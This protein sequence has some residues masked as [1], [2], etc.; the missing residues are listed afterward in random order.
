MNN[1]IKILILLCASYLSAFAQNRLSTPLEILTFM[2]ATGTHYQIEQLY[3]AVPSRPAP[4]LPHGAFIENIAGIEHTR[5]YKDF[6][7]CA[8]EQ[9]FAKARAMMNTEKPNYKK[10]RSYYQKILK[11]FP[12]D[13]Q[14]YTLVGETYLEEKQFD[15][16]RQW[17]QEAI[18]RN[19]IDYLAYWDI[20]EMYATEGNLDSAVR[21][22]TLAHIYN[23]NSP[24]LL[25][26]LQE[27][28]SQNQRQYLRDW[29]FQPQYRVYKDTGTQSIVIVA[30][31]AWLT[32]A[33]YK[34]VWE[35]EPDYLYIKQKQAV[36]DYLFHQEMEASIGTF[37]TFSEM[38]KEDKRNYP[39]MR[40]FEVALDNEMVEEYVFYEILLVERPTIANHATPEFLERLQNYIFR[41]RSKEY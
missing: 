39:S 32:Y 41:V 30:D 34:A 9:N 13:A 29:A 10:V 18:R 23:R 37:M 25:L 40:A 6:W 16:A 36:T 15:K 24:R 22:I 31:G 38:K 33:L 5:E 26:R 1:K 35:F 11:E 4:V 12:N 14:I 17:L 20:A 27:I 19:P 28:Y 21:N 3:G 7:T 2:E 8:A